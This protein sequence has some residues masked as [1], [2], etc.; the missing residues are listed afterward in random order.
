MYIKK[1][2]QILFLTGITALAMPVAASAASNGQIWVNGENIVQAEEHKVACGTGSA[3][4]DPQTKTLTL[5]NAVITQG[6]SY[7][8][9]I[10]LPS[11]IDLN[12]VLTGNN[13]ITGEEVLSDDGVGQGIYADGNIK[14]SGTGTLTTV[15]NL[16]ALKAMG[17]VEIDGVALDLTVNKDYFAIHANGGDVTIQ[18]NAVVKAENQK[19]TMAGALIAGWN[20][21]NIES[22]K[23]NAVSSCESV[24][25]S[26]NGS[27]NIT[28]SQVELEQKDIGGTIYAGNEIAISGENTEVTATCGANTKMANMYAYNGISIQSGTVKSIS[29]NNGLYTD[30]TLEISEAANVTVESANTGYTGMQ[31]A[32]MTI[33][34]KN[35]TIS[36]GT[37]AINVFDGIINLNVPAWASVNAD[38]TSMEKFSAEEF[39]VYKWISTKPIYLS[40]VTDVVWDTSE[41]GKVSWSKVDCAAGYE[42]QLYKDGIEEENKVG[43][44][45]NVTEG[46]TYNFN[47]SIVEA[48]TYYFTVKA[49]G[50]EGY[51]LD[52]DITKSY[53][54]EFA[55]MPVKP[56]PPA[57]TDQPDKTVKP[58]DYTKTDKGQEIPKTGDNTTPE[59]WIAILGISGF[60]GV[61]ILL[62]NRAG[63]RKKL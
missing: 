9:G 41:R 42:L 25:Q 59:I 54:C 40:E 51:S 30:N 56:V 12:I 17:N 47:Q 4:Y 37:R 34:S 5:E 15:T 8:R 45:V 58:A 3:S 6:N 21:V 2:F 52:S 46:T 48:G 38:R 14:I 31:A 22:S 10:D 50:E 53:S 33:N 62:G 13:Y 27:V 29:G 63:N 7:K 18:N 49:L 26:G 11:D 39:T 16:D 28:D 32:E 1:I 44:A 35:V 43:N 36:G 23:I 20:S 19:G 61:C 60:V 55:A 57:E 24:I